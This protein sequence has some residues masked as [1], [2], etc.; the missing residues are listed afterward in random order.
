MAPPSLV[1]DEVYPWWVIS[2]VAKKTNE[3]LI[4]RIVLPAHPTSSNF[5][6]PLSFMH[7][8]EETDSFLVNYIF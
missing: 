6:F 1:L 2:N 3:N 8:L 5:D 7:H 4:V